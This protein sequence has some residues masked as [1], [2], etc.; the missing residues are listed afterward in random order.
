MAKK[1]IETGEDCDN[2]PESMRQ[3]LAQQ[4]MELG[5][6]LSRAYLAPGMGYGPT[7]M[8]GGDIHQSQKVG[9]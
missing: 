3:Y 5:K 4:A 6:P 9:Q 2:I 1:S 8:F 7:M